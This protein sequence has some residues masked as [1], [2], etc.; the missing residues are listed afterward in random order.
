MAMEADAINNTRQQSAAGLKM[1]RTI[2]TGS[3]DS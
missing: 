3:V 1:P 2:L